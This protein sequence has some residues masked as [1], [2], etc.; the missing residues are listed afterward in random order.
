M[1]TAKLYITAGGF[2]NRPEAE[3]AVVVQARYNGTYEG[4]SWLAFP[5]DPHMLTETPWT[6]WAASDIEC[7]DFW[8]RANQER[9][10][11]GRGDDPSAAY[12]DLVTRVCELG[13]VDPADFTAAPE[14]PAPRTDPLSS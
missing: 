7:Q 3:P 13:S 11:I 4:R 6:D 9:W 12:I 14:W 5:V 2:G 1:L 10:P 8:H